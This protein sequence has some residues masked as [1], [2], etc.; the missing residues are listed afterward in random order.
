MQ[1]D[2]SRLLAVTK[3]RDRLRKA[4]FGGG[5]ERLPKTIAFSSEWLQDFSAL[6]D[7][8]LYAPVGQSARSFWGVPIKVEPLGAHAV[9][10]FADGQRESVQLEPQ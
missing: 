8:E 6:R 1:G 7:A 5:A 3:A 9:I 10:T 2:V 4:A